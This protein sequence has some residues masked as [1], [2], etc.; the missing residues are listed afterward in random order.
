MERLTQ[1][2]GDTVLYVGH[3][4]RYPGLDCAGNMRVAAVRECMDRLAEYEDTGFTPEEL[5]EVSQAF[6]DAARPVVEW[7]VELAP[8][9]ADTLLAAMQNMT[10]EQI[11]KLLQENLQKN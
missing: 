4:C 2:D 7:I 8:Q 9:V 1:R 3:R 11:T 5:R 10:P 6:I